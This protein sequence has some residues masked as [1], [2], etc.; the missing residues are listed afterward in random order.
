VNRI[1]FTFGSLFQSKSK[2]MILIVVI[3]V[4]AIIITVGL[5]LPLELGIFGFFVF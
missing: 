4:L 3:I 2:Q 5:I 1:D